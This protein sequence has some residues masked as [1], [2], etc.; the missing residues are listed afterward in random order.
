MAFSC[1]T[2]SRVVIVHVGW[3]DDIDKMERLTAMTWLWFTNQSCMDQCD[4]EMKNV[5][6]R[7][8]CI[9]H[10]IKS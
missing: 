9:V 7:H 4:F 8:V 6:V 3:I 5:P 2:I 1:H 10:A